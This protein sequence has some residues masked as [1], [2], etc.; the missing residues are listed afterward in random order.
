MVSH[1]ENE[2]TDLRE[3]TREVKYTSYCILWGN[4]WYYQELLLESDTKLE[5]FLDI[6][7]FNISSSS[8]FLSSHF[9]VPITQI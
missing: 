5:N 7:P 3:N 9:K 4:A 2:I 6:I 1:H 8:F